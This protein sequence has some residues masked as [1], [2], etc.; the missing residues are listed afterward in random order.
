M[1]TDLHWAILRVFANIIKP[2]DARWVGGPQH[3]NCNPLHIG[4]DERRDLI[5]DHLIK[6]LPGYGRYVWAQAEE[7][8]NRYTKETD[9]VIDG[10]I[11]VYESTFDEVVKEVQ[12]YVSDLVLTALDAR[13]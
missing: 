12:V 3:D 1:N 9:S 10:F 4:F 13:W 5:H 11:Q 6:T 7:A 2:G 8:E